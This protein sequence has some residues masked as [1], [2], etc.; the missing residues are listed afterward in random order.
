MTAHPRHHTPAAP[1]RPTKRM[2]DFDHTADLYGDHGQLEDTPAGFDIKR[3]YGAWGADPDDGG[4][5]YSA[6]LI[7]L[8]VF[9]A[10]V[11]RATAVTLFGEDAVAVIEAGAAY[12]YAG[13]VQRPSQSVS[14]NTATTL[15][16]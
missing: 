7:W 11:D 6:R 5:A 16:L 4:Y 10:R 2:A 13:Q 1:V 14:T 9:K 12:S 8:Q 3:E 15:P